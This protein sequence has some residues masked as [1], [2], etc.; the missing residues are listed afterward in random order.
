MDL[1]SYVVRYDSG[2]APNPFFGFCTLATCKPPIRRVA[3]VGDWVIGSGSA[4]K[5]VKRGGTLVYAMKISEVLTFEDYFDD[6]RFHRKKPNLHGS[7]KQARGDNI[8]FKVDDGWSQLDSFHT[9]KDGSPNSDH[10]SR[11]TGVNRVLISNNF[12][13]FGMDGPQIPAGLSV[14]DRQLCHHGVGRRK[15]SGENPDEKVTIDNFIAWF[16]TVGDEGYN[17]HPFDWDE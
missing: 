9:N 3:Q 8:Y 15:L 10:I 1:Y 13:Y 12:K 2:F 11:D 14:G 7:R 6:P 16:D 5:K 4:A 17:S